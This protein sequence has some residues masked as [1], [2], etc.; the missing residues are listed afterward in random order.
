MVEF[1]SGRQGRTQMNHVTN[2]KNNMK[3]L[4]THEELVANVGKRIRCT[5]AG[6]Q[7]VGVIE[8]S[9]EGT[10]SYEYTSVALDCGT[11]SLMSNSRYGI[12]AGISDITLLDE[13]EQYIPKFGERA[14]F[15]DYE[16]VDKEAIFIA[17]EPSGKVYVTCDNDEYQLIKSNHSTRVTCFKLCKP[18]EK[19]TL[20]LT[21]QQIAEKYGVDEVVIEE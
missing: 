20:T 7:M 13:P 12:F 1:Y 16:S 15:R 9:K 17:Y 21:K 6:E 2:A 18:L 14:L 8:V 10:C 3:K 19:K 4:T 11:A 5:D